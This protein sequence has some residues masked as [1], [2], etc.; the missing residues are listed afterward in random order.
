MTQ[1][2]RGSTVTAGGNATIGATRTAGASKDSAQDSS[3][4]IQ[5]RQKCNRVRVVCLPEQAFFC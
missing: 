4:T 2:A 3:L 5:G 1:T